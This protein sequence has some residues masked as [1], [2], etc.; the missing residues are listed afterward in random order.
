MGRHSQRYASH[1][2]TAPAPGRRSRPSP[3][4]DAAR[5]GIRRT[6]PSAVLP[7]TVL[8]ART[9]LPG[10][11]HS[12][13]YASHPWT[14][15]AP[16]RRSRPSPPP[17]AAR[18][19]IRRTRPSAV[20]PCTVLG[21]RTCLPGGR[22]SQRYVPLLVVLAAIWGASYLFIK[23]GVRDF[24]PTTLMSLRMLIAAVPLFAFLCRG[25]GVPGRAVPDI[26][27]ASG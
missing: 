16:G 24:E 27:A 21:P 9:C 2:W 7:C 22:D 18:C 14:A 23:V 15:P 8:G 11:R 26:G 20:L 4:P 3:P 10:E 25:G 6:R 17:D 12:Q 13:R 5:C 1:P 19:G